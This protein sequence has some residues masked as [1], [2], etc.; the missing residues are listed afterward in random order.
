M[1][2]DEMESKLLQAHARRKEEAQRIYESLSR[3]PRSAFEEVQ[4]HLEKAARSEGDE[5]AH[6]FD[7]AVRAWTRVSRGLTEEEQTALL[8]CEKTPFMTKEIAEMMIHNDRY[9]DRGERLGRESR[10]EDRSRDRGGHDR[11]GRDR[12]GFRR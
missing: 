2:S 6:A 7:N 3:K 5:F 9:I 1:L 4:G 10:G 11:G 8:R 12:G